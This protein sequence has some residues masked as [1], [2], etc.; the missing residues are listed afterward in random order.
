MDKTGAF[1]D[2]SKYREGFCYGNEER[3]EFMGSLGFY[4]LSPYLFMLLGMGICFLIFKLGIKF[5]KDMSKPQAEK[6]DKSFY[7][8]D[9]PCSGRIDVAYWLLYH[10]SNIKK[11]DLNNGLLG[12]Y[13]LSWYKKGYI[14]I[15]S[16]QESGYSKENFRIDLKDGNWDQNWIEQKIYDF[17][18]SAAG[19]NNLLEKNEICNYCCVDGNDM[20]LRYLFKSILQEVQKEL[21]NQ[22]YITVI[23]AK[24]YIFF[25][26]EE[27]ITLSEDLQREYQ[28]LCG[29]K[30]F[31]ADNS[32]MEEKRHIEV[33]LWEDYLIFA[34]LLGIADKVRKQLYKIYPNFSAAHKL[35]EVSMDRTL[36]GQLDS[37]AKH[38]GL[39]FFALLGSV[40][41]ILL[42]FKADAG[43]DKIIIAILFFCILGGLL[44]W[45][46]HKYLLN[47]KVK[48]MD[49]KTR[50]R[51]IDVEA[52]HERDYDPE[53]GR[54]YTKTTYHFK[55]EYTVDGTCFTGRGHSKFKKRKN[56][57]IKIYYNKVR[58]QYSETA[59]R[60]NEF[61]RIVIFI[62]AII[63]LLYIGLIITD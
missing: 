46:L 50:A 36:V 4:L 38:M 7:Y 10:F 55:Y 56:Q 15:E 45:L 30:N 1:P 5:L 54:E 16:V 63:A 24:N 20:Q 35:F 26:T 12:A 43:V 29:L 40:V 52:H 48:E 47:K 49:G 22:N 59:E 62:V 25:N 17:L 58:P 42:M 32:C 37:V 53:D 57:K 9:I 8:R 23:P 14:E 44:G 21:M 31:L 18:K 61:L 2:W 34:N 19:N 13:L 3:E 28:N 39:Q 60:H 27:K 33:H 11:D 6:V 51:I 41:L